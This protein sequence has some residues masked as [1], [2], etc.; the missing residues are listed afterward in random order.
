MA[1]VE[2]TKHTTENI[3]VQV[4]KYEL[5]DGLWWELQQANPSL[6]EYHHIN[7]DDCM[8]CTGKDYHNNTYEYEPSRKATQR[9]LDIH[10]A[11]QNLK[12]FLDV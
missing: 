6:K 1:Q 9:E 3:K 2:A 4:S 12:G 5:L 8:V 11:F 7:G 10:M